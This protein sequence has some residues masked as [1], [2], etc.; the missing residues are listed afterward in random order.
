MGI[1]APAPLG[2]HQSFWE[3]TG[4]SRTR[5][6]RPWYTILPYQGALGVSRMGI[7]RNLKDVEKSK[8]DDSI[9]T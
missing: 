1:T 6:E 2:K 9:E 5:Q 4:H 8:S 7:E 3:G